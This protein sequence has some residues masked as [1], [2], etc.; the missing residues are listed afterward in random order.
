MSPESVVTENKQ[1]E[2]MSMWIVV[3]LAAALLGCTAHGNVYNLA[4]GEKTPFSYTYNGS[5]HGKMTATFANGEVGTGEYSI[6]V[7][8][9]V[10]W[11][12][13]YGSV[14]GP[15]GSVAGSATATSVSQ[16]GRRQGEAILTGNKGSI[17]TCEFT[18]GMTG[19]GFGA[20]QSK[21]GEL[22]KVLF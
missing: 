9:S 1:P 7:G 17:L 10:G 18:V 14:Y 15:T 19:H 11:G 22:Y 5:G 13:V 16:E 20:C 4:T 8:G 21:T 12:S 6:V 3:F 2:R